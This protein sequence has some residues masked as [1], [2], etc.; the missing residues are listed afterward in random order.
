VP[1]VKFVFVF[2]NITETPG[3]GSPLLSVTTPFTRLAFDWALT[4]GAITIEER[5]I[6]A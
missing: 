2:L 4:A 1:E 6:R 3:R 5:S